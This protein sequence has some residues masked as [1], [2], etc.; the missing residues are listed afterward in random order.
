[1]Q[2]TCDDGGCYGPWT[3]CDGKPVMT[4]VAMALGNNAMANRT[5]QINQTKLIVVSAKAK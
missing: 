2:K 5:A 4:E 3:Q 1:M